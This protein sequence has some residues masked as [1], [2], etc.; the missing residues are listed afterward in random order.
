[1]VSNVFTFSYRDIQD[2]TSMISLIDDMKRRTEQPAAQLLLQNSDFMYWY[3]FALVRRNQ[4]TDRAKALDVIEKLCND[5]SYSNPDG[6]CLCGRIY[7]DMFAESKYINRS[8][9]LKAI[10][11]Y[12]KGFSVSMTNSNSLMFYHHLVSFYV[13]S[14]C[15][16]MEVRYLLIQ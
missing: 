8:Q 15:F 7:K 2:Y 1:M 12:R 9:L 14:L 4:P 6:V 10:E 11:W 3:S 13:S 16:F 5:T